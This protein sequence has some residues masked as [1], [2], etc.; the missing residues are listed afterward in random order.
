MKNINEANSTDLF[1]FDQ[2]RLQSIADKRIVSQGLEDNRNNRVIHIDQDQGLLWSRVEGEDPEIP[3][4]VTV[5]AA[6]NELSFDC[7]CDET[8]DKAVCRHIVALLCNY[9]DQYGETDV[10]LTAAD[11]AIKDRAKRGRSEVG[12]TRLSGDPWFG[13]WR[14]ESVGGST[15]FSPGYR[16]SMRSLKHR[17]NLCTCPDFANNQLG[18]CKHIEAVLHKVK[19]LPDFEQFKEQPP[20]WPYTYIAWDME[21]AP[22]LWCIERRK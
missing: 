17:A 20:P 5:S 10:L 6:N 22:S 19:K 4:D 16:V 12:V 1:F 21:N 18:T 11:T 14:A 8:P 9:A 7:D 13:P 3:H 2:E 15:H